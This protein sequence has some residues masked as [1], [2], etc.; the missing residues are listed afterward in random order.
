LAEEIG[1]SSAGLYILLEDLY[2]S[3]GPADKSAGNSGQNQ[4]SSVAPPVG[5]GRLRVALPAVSTAGSKEQ[6]GY[7]SF[8]FRLHPLISAKPRA[9]VR[10]LRATPVLWRFL[11]M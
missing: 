2:S 5:V 6:F 10:A 11:K 3:F 4:P 8:S 7:A 1:I 9:S